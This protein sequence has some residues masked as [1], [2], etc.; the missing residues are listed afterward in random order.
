MIEQEKGVQYRHGSRESSLNEWLTEIGLPSDAR[1]FPCVGLPNVF[2]WN[3]VERTE[4]FQETWL[5]IPDSTLESLLASQLEGAVF[6]EKHATA[7]NSFRVDN[8]TLYPIFWAGKLDCIVAVPQGKEFKGIK[9]DLV[10]LEKIKRMSAS[11]DKADSVRIAYEFV[12]RLFDCK[13][14][15][16]EFAQRLLNFLTDQVDK[17]YV[18]LYWK[19]AD[20]YHR[21]WAY[22]DLQLSDKL[23]LAVTSDIVGKWKEINSRG[24]AF[25]PAELMQEE[26]V[27]VQAPPSF[28]FV[29]Q[30]PNCGDREQWLVMAVPG[31]ISGAAVSRITIIASL[32]NSIDDDRTTGYAELVGLFGDLLNQDRKTQSAEEALK[33]CFKLI[34]GKLRLNSMCLLDTDH[35]I[36]RCVKVAEDQIQIEKN[37]VAQVPQQ[38]QEVMD[39]LEPAFLP[40]HSHPPRDSQNSTKKSDVSHVL[41]PVP[42]KDGSVAL[43]SAEFTSNLEKARHY[44]RLFEYAA[45][46]LGLCLSLAKIS[47]SKPQ[48]I[49]TPSSAIAESIA[50]A[51]LKTLSR[52][53]GGYFH[54]LTE[55]LSVILGQ[56]EIMEYEIQKSTKPLT[57]ADLLLSTERIVRA[58]GSLASRLEVLKEVSTIKA[59]D[60]GKYVWADQ[61]LDM[62]PTLT[63][64]YFLTVKDDK[65]VEIA[66][67]TK[68]DRNVSF[69]IP[70]LHIY[71]YILPLIL[72]I[73]D[74]ALC[75]GTI[76][77]SLT[78]H[79]GRPGLR[80]SWPKKL[81][82]KQTLEK[83]VDRVFNYQQCE[84]SDDGVLLISVEEAKFLFSGSAA[85]HY[86]SIY[87]LTNLHQPIEEFN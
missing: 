36:V 83:L 21:R 29:C 33:H 86:Q 52:L 79:F 50:L 7:A 22:G 80:L 43:L 60:F 4:S 69:S 9:T 48:I 3:N 27:F 45:R 37:Q 78:E 49:G 23:P 87:T 74:E 73:M 34:D 28:L 68:S 6:G 39:S 82:G 17:S 1:L 77:A 41:Y 58:A 10:K 18:G 14:S 15:Y 57:T 13:Q 24:K 72:Y 81:L 31:D 2:A 11:I 76:V 56:A 40:G 63:Y 20:N 8:H 85:D 35:S 42:L 30:T 51:R 59:I 62:L 66:V 75:S 67:Q 61:F 64:G 16:A 70:V 5:Y 25:M 47:L 65:N 55:F 46:Y 84:K 19:G 71:D 53:N 54:E 38:A 12:A 26:P 44:Q 32:L